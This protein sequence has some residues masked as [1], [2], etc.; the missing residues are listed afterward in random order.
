MARKHATDWE[1]A[2]RGVKGSAM[3][4]RAIVITLAE[5]VR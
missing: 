2:N 5:R 4:H 3:K 1:A